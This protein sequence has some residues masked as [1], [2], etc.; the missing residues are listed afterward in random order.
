MHLTNGIVDLDVAAE[1]G[2]RIV[3][4]GFC[5]DANLLAD[6]PHL[7][8]PTPWGDWTPR[9]GHR[10]W[11]APENMPG[12]YAPDAAPVA[13]DDAGPLAVVVRQDTDCSGVQKTIAVR[14]AADA[15]TVFL[16]H[17]IANRT[18]WPI[19]VAPWAI[20]IVVPGT[21]AVPQPPFRP[22][23]EALLP[24][25]TLVQWAYTNL[26]DPRWTFG[27]EL[28]L[29]TPDAARQ[30]PQKIGI[31]GGAAWC[32]LIRGGTVFMKRTRPDPAAEYP[33]RGSAIEIFTAGD[34]LELETLGPLQVL[35]PGATATHVEQWDLFRGVDLGS[36]ESSRAAVLRALART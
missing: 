29:L 25:Q 8:T 22:H 14:L 32:A 4:Y 13:I 6:V 18:A 5:G 2:P 35:V 3:R 20:T 19:R 10:L 23:P 17:T 9:G 15:S 36:S 26:S 12:S 27:R 11:V 34:Y 28:I 1:F 7:S 21:V 33:D 30:E 16:D 24:E 31:G